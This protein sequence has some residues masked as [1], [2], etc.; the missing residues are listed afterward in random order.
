V[1]TILFIG[2]SQF[3]GYY[4]VQ[5]ALSGGHAVTL[6][7]RGKTDPG[8]FPAAEH[9]IGD[10]LEDIERLRGRHFDAVIDTC[11]YIPRAV[12]KSAELLK[13]H[14]GQYLF[15]SS[16][17]VYADMADGNDETSPLSTLPDP[18]T[19]DVSAHYGGLKVACET[20]VQELFPD[21]SVIVRPGLIVGTRDSTDRFD[22]WV[23]RIAEGGEVLAPATPDRAVQAIDARDL[24][25]WLIHLVETQASGVYNA[26]GPLKPLTM[27][28]FLATCKS[29]SASDATITWVDE[30]WLLEHKVEP[31]S[32]L[33]LWVPPDMI[34]LLQTKIDRAV[35]AGLTF[36]PLAETV[37]GSLAWMRANPDK[38]SRRRSAMKREREAELLGEWHT[39]PG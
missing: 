5:S 21:K 15:I 29:A 20:V 30:S 2:G 35:A 24:G 14:A 37:Q 4:A 17:S 23:E 19:E 13:D 26:V 28:D 10:R 22:Y 11:G 12:R 31:W 6:F 39:I 1:A 34:G 3:V 8:A 9:I 7:N 33:P 16:V 38:V 32:E 27:G 18:A 36:R 25:E